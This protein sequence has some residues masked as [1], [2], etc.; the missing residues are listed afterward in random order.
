[1]SRPLIDAIRDKKWLYADPAMADH[2][3]Y[4]K[5]DLAGLLELGVPER[6]VEVLRAA[7]FRHV[8]AVCQESA[9]IAPSSEGEHGLVFEDPPR[10]I[11]TAHTWV[12]RRVIEK[13]YLLFG[14]SSAGGDPYC[15]DLTGAELEDPPVV[16]LSTSGIGHPS[17]ES[18]NPVAPV[19]RRASDLIRAL[20]FVR[21]LS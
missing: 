12:G 13:G 2:A 14:D 10:L 1:M 21:S 11:E 18:T 16:L 7:P 3:T 5:N 17:W 19:C 20:Q 6:T 8:E 9:L 4:S 15:F